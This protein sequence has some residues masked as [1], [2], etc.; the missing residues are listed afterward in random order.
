MIQLI[1]KIYLL[2]LT[3][4]LTVVLSSCAFD[5]LMRAY[6]TFIE[7]DYFVYA[8]YNDVENSHIYLYGLTQE[9]KK[10]KYLILPQTDPMGFQ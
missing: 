4:L 3:I 9:G 8:T 6:Y 1:K 10:Q 5:R 2:I 7:D